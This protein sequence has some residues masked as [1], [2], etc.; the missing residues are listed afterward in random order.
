MHCWQGLTAVPAAVQGV[1]ALR[2]RSLLATTY[3]S[4]VADVTMEM[5]T[6]SVSSVSGVNTSVVDAVDDGTLAVSFC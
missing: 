1:T 3:L 6:G 5:N 4:N 2:R